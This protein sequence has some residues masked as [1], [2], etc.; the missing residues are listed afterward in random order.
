MKKLI[1]YLFHERSRGKW[2]KWFCHT[3]VSEC[4]KCGRNHYTQEPSLWELNRAAVVA[5]ICVVVLVAIGYLLKH[6]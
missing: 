4:R 3:Y 2:D 6:A 5:A 1:C